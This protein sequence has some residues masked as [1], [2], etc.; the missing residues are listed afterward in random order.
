MGYEHRD[1]LL[2]LQWKWVMGRYRTP[3]TVLRD[4]RQKQVMK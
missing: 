3:D 4:R 2:T 1:K